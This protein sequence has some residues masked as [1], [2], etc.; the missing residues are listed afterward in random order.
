MALIRARNL[1]Q[2]VPI[3]Y[4]ALCGR[5]LNAGAEAMMTSYCGLGILQ[6][7]F[8]D[9]PA[10]PSQLESFFVVAGLSRSCGLFRTRNSEIAPF[11]SQC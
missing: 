1:P 5:S 6:K 9:L 4:Y 3:M 8:G 11:Y 7:D 10:L 2:Q